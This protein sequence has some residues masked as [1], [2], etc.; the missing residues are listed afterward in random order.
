MLVYDDFQVF[1]IPCAGK[2]DC[3]ADF[4]VYYALCVDWFCVVV[5]GTCK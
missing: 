1:N 2:C 5:V 4:G 3:N